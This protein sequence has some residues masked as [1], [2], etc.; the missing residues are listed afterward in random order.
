MA[1][2]RVTLDHV[3]WWRTRLAD[4]KGERCAVLARGALN[5]ILVA[6]ADGYKVI[7]SRY[8]VRRLN[9]HATI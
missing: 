2:R 5:S 3:W 7:T 6:F 1:D 8:A 4:R 9:P